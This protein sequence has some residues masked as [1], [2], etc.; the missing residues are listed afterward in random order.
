MHIHNPGVSKS[1]QCYKES[2]ILEAIAPSEEARL[3]PEK[4]LQ[5]LCFVG[6]V[7]GGGVAHDRL[8]ILSSIFKPTYGGGRLIKLFDVGRYKKSLLD[9]IH[10]I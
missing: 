2:W 4:L 8:E 5:G 10:I 9:Q 1:I 6:L 3:E 7:F